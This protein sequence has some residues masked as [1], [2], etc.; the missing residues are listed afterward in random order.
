MSIQ[1]IPSFRY[2][3][4]LIYYFND[5]SSDFLLIGLCTYYLSRNISLQYLYSF[6]IQNQNAI[7]LFIASKVVQNLTMELSLHRRKDLFG[8]R[9]YWWWRWYCSR[10][11]RR[12]NSRTWSRIEHKREICRCTVVR[13]ESAGNSNFSDVVFNRIYKSKHGSDKSRNLH[14]GMSI[15]NPHESSNGESQVSS[16]KPAFSIHWIK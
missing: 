8:G 10:W 16:C 9:I 4:H 2:P 1:T 13:F 7:Y 5:F 3:N 14:S 11:V 6:F 15:W 12:L